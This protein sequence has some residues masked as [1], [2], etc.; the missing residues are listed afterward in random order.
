M[1]REPAVIIGSVV[2][3]VEAAVAVLALTLGWDEVL[4]AA[5]VAVVAA[6]GGVATSALVV[7]VA[8]LNKKAKLGKAGLRRV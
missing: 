8:K 5:V 7:P 2:A 6:A 1:K 3:L 4:V